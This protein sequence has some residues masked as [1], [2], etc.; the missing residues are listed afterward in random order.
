MNHG[1]GYRKLGR[2]SSHRKALLRNLATS[3]LEHGRIK[4]TVP[5]AK[6]LRR[7]VEKMITL[8]KRG[9][10]HAR[11]QVESVLFSTEVSSKVFKDLAGR[12]AT[13]NGGYT[14]IVRLGERFGD[15]AEMCNFELVDFTAHEGKK[16]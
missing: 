9:D 2:E 8:G 15:G 12:F 16:A 5:K 11:R 10:L 6:E 13:R 7:V 1:H 14:R 4:T 3:F